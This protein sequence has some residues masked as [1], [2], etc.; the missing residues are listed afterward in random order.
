MKECRFCKDI[1]DWVDIDVKVNPKDR[2]N[3]YNV[4]LLIDSETGGQYNSG[5]IMSYRTRQGIRY[6][7]L[8]GILIRPL[9]QRQKKESTTGQKKKSMTGQRQSLWN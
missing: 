4:Q 6:C 3:I 1:R 7:P 9:I 2:N 5:M 8:C